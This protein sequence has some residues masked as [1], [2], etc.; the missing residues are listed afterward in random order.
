MSD[1]LTWLVRDGNGSPW[2]GATPT[3]IIYDRTGVV[4]SMPTPSNL[5]GGI[6]AVFPSDADTELGVVALIDNGDLAQTRYV[7]GVSSLDPL[8][9]FLLTDVVTGALWVGAVPTLG[10]YVNNAG[11]D[12]SPHPS[13]AMLFSYLAVLQPLSSV[14]ANYRVDP[15]AGASIDHDQSAFVQL[16]T[17]EDRSPA[18]LQVIP[19][20]RRL[21]VGDTG[22]LTWQVFYDDGSGAFDLT[23]CT[24][25]L[26]GQARDGTQV[27]NGRAMN[28]VDVAGLL[29]YAPQTG[30]V[31]ASK[32]LDLQIEIT[33]PDTTKTTAP[34]RGNASLVI[35]PKA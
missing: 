12:L 21:K 28:V 33:L 8:D 6:Y 23:G 32:S 22:L 13:F 15:P 18:L 30:E 5:G 14:D 10:P 29:S 3:C 19:G 9:A 31:A 11:V 20:E 24:A 35:E 16:P 1:R 26:F 27:I 34:A 2:A 17:G 25:K 7:I 4:R